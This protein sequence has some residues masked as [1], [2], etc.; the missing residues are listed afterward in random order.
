LYG[1]ISLLSRDAITLHHRDVHAIY[2]F[3]LFHGRNPDES[4]TPHHIDNDLP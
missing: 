4:K 3:R 1:E 2:C